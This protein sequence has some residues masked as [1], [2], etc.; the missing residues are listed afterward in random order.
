LA[1]SAWSIEN[2]VS[3]T[4]R[5]ASRRPATLDHFTQPDHDIV[6]EFPAVLVDAER[7]KKNV[8]VTAV[9][10]RTAVYHPIEDL[11]ERRLALLSSFVV[12]PQSIRYTRRD[13]PKYYPRSNRS[14]RKGGAHN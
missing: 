3:A 5:P 10:E 1:S 12:Q 7:K 13:W 6:G 4:V 11:T 14:G 8:V 9:L 2:R